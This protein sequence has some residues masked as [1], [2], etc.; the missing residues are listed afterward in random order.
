MARGNGRA[1]FSVDADDCIG[2]GLCDDRAPNN[3]EVSF[4]EAV[5]CVYRQPKTDAEEISCFEA[6]DY[7]PTGGLRAEVSEGSNP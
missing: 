3:V 2:C 5:A 7:C 4:D 1:R 6:A